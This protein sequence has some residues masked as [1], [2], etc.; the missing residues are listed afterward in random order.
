MDEYRHILSFEKEHW[1]KEIH[2]VEI[3]PLDLHVIQ[4]Q[5]CEFDKYKRESGA[6][7]RY[8]LS[9]LDDKTKLSW[10][11]L[12]L[13][14]DVLLLSGGSLPWNV[15]RDKVLTQLRTDDSMVEQDSWHLDVL[16]CLPDEYLSLEDDLVRLPFCRQ[17][18]K[19][20]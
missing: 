6:V 17:I 3:E 19:C 18:I 15:L 5:C 16:A 2:G 7:R 14:E 12:Q 4:F 9:D 10:H 13:A 20:T 1:P 11:M 8:S